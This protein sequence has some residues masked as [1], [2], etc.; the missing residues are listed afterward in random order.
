MRSNTLTEYFSSSEA[1]LQEAQRHR[2]ALAI[3][4]GKVYANWKP[5]I[6]SLS[7]EAPLITVAGGEEVKTLPAL[8]RLWK[9]LWQYRV[10]KGQTV[11][12]IG[13]GSVLDVGGFAAATWKRGTPFI[14]VPTTLIAQVDAAFGGKVGLNFRQG[15]NLI[16]TYA[17]PQAVWV[18]PDF[19]RTLPPR[20]LRAGWVE[21]YKQALLSDQ[22]LWSHLQSLS[23][24]TIPSVELLQRLV[25]IKMRY[26]EQDPREEQG[27]RQALNLGHTL[28]HVWES[29]SLRT[30]AP[31]LH[32]EAVA[33][34]L[35]QEIL[36]SAQTNRLPKA[37]AEAILSKLRAEALMLPLPTFTWSAWEKIL[38]QDK[39]VRNGQI[40]LPLLVEIGK[41]QLVPVSIQ[42]LKAS[43]RLYQALVAV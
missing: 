12:L 24:S 36:L 7:G 4:D 28:G 32:G 21:C 29:L 2:F 23:F 31:L 34:G 1:L 25:S 22:S 19:L 42:A 27:I 20:E 16:G 17:D 43:V 6:D 18:A 11:L 41:V 3:C 14:S 33:M 37:V 5:L 26:V 35:I 9:K 30:Q 8:R 40:F 10:D 13:G 39:K 15:K 38:L